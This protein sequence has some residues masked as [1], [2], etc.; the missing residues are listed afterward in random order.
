[1]LTLTSRERISALLAALLGSTAC[2]DL[3][4]PTDPAKASVLTVVA[5]QSQLEA[6]GISSTLVTAILAK[7]SASGTEVIFATDAGTLTGSGPTPGKEL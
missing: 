6:N 1:M 7:E 3:D 5:E 4:N 2:F